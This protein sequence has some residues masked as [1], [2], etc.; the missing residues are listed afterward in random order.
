MDE[1]DM[2]S[3]G[4][5]YELNLQREA[6]KEEENFNLFYDGIPTEEVD[7]AEPMELN[8]DVEEFLFEKSMESSFDKLPEISSTKPE[9]ISKTVQVLSPVR[10]AQYKEV[11]LPLPEIEGVDVLDYTSLLIREAGETVEMFKLR[12]DIAHKIARANFP[13]GPN[14]VSLDNRGILSVSRMFLN[15]LWFGMSY[16]P[17]QEKLLKEISKYVEGL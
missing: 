16:N 15:K 1:L 7:L 17:D 2:A 10:K 14:F 11:F 3:V 5:E 6:E 4:S 9:K 13:R 12:V 8:E